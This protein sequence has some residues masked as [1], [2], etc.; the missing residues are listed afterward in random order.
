MAKTRMKI[1]VSLPVEDV[2]WLRAEA[3]KLGRPKTHYSWEVH[4][5]ILQRRISMLTKWQREDI[6]RK[7]AAAKEN[8]ERTLFDLAKK[9]EEKKGETNDVDGN[10]EHG[11]AGGSAGLGEGR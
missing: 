11:E 8:E 4:K 7:L 10:G 6:Y 1:T 3:D 5:A 2:I 9:R